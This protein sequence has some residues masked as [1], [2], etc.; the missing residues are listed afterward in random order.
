MK[1]EFL[2]AGKIVNTHGTLGEVRIQPWADS[3]AFLQGFETLYI[4]GLPMKLLGSRLHKRFLLARFEGVADI[5]AAIALK[6]GAR[7]LRTIVEERMRDLMYE[8]PSKTNIIRVTITEEVILKT[9]EPIVEYVEAYEQFELKPL[10]PK[11]IRTTNSQAD[12]V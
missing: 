2:E 1:K 8:F 9:G 3:A 5:D 4:D 7:S 12:V 10:V 6:T 11:A